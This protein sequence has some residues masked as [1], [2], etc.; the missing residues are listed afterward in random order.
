MRQGRDF[1]DKR[2]LR[3]QHDICHPHERV[4]ARGEHLDVGVRVVGHG[5]VDGGALGAADPAVLRGQRTV[6]PVD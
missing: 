6:R 1:R 2:V 4:R 5:E 3:R